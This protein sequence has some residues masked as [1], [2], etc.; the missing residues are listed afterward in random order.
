MYFTAASPRVI[1]NEA[2]MTLSKHFLRISRFWF[3]QDILTW[4]LVL[5]LVHLYTFTMPPYTLISFKTIGGLEGRG[6][7]I[8]RKIGNT[9]LCINLE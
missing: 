3:N 8:A 1:C 7:F 5:L 2:Y 9:Y 4:W 6:F